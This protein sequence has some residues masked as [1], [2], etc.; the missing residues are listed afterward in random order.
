MRRRSA[1]FKTHFAT[2]SCDC[3]VWAKNNCTYSFIRTTC[4]TRITMTSTTLASYDHV[5]RG[6][7]GNRPSLVREV[8]NANNL[9]NAGGDYLGNGSRSGKTH[10]PT[11]HGFL[12][13]VINYNR[14]DPQYVYNLTINAS[15]GEY[16]I[17]NVYSCL[18]DSLFSWQLL[19]RVPQMP[20]G[21]IESF[22][23]D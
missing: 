2:R 5:K 13:E 7:D 10:G 8:K 1:S 16:L 3:V 19:S 6:P 9:F 11:R 14:L 12:Y 18:T 4:T 21:E 23:Q 15:T 20:K 22:I 17:S